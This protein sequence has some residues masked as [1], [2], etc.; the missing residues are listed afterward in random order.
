MSGPAA[1]PTPIPAALRPA[2]ST[3]ADL[4]GGH[5]I[6][7]IWK[8]RGS[9]AL[10]PGQSPNEALDRLEPLL[11]CV[12][13]SH[14]RTDAELHFRK[15][16]PAAQDKL[17]IYDSGTLTVESTTEGDVLRYTLRSRILLFCF[18]LPLLFVG[19]ARLTVE[20]GKRQATPVADATKDKE[21][22]AVMH[23]L[24]KVLGAPVPDKEGGDTAA[25]KAKEKADKSE[26]ARRKYS[27]MPALVFM[28]IFAALYVVGR[29][30]EAALA[31]RLFRRQLQQC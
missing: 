17:S 3:K 8:V 29:I 26:K 12:G 15:K 30:L 31:K 13:T 14:E 21:P 19:V 27:P 10:A 22:P 2:S 7:W 24:D 28:G 25:E 23:P 16:D 4:A 9:L 11:D 5:F 20:V 1:S 6:D 18:L